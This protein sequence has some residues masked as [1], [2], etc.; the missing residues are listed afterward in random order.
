MRELPARLP[1]TLRAL[2][3][4]PLLAAAIDQPRASLVCG[5][6]ARSC[7]EVAGQGRLGAA[8]T[9][10]AILYAFGGWLQLLAL[11]ALAGAV[12]AVA[13]RAVPAARELIRSLRPA[14]PRLG[15][16][17]ELVRVGL[18]PAAVPS[19]GRFTRLA[20][21]RAPPAAA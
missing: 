4:V 12:L 14:A 13:L 20:R 9:L 17:G 18:A 7:L 3:L 1:L 15:A 21:D 6:D 16:R 8:G 2:V 5:S 10:A 11:G 19:L